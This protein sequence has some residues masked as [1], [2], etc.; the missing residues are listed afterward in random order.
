[1]QVRPSFPPLFLLLL[2]G[3]GKRK[4]NMLIKKIHFHCCPHLR[5]VFFINIYCKKGVNLTFVPK[6]LIILVRIAYGI[7][8]SA[9]KLVIH[10]DWITHDHIYK[11]PKPNI[12]MLSWFIEN[13]LSFI[14]SAIRKTISIIKSHHLSAIKNHNSQHGV[15]MFLYLDE[16]DL[17]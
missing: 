12:Y 13:E 3:I 8:L 7:S 4:T 16:F 10:H 6:A 17:Y 1:M 9:L 15:Y 5:F 14:K 2:S 11:M